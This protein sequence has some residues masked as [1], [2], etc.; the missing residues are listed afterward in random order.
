MT[1]LENDLAAPRS[2]VNVW[3]LTIG[4]PVLQRVPA[5]PSRTF[6][7]TSPPPVADALATQPVRGSTVPE[8]PPPA[9][10]SVYTFS[11]AIDHQLVDVPVC[12]T[13]RY[14]AVRAG[15]VTVTLAV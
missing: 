15:N 11:S 1:S 8:P 10:P 2:S 5:L 14:R 13:L 9:V 3:P 4:V 6:A 12:T 7:G